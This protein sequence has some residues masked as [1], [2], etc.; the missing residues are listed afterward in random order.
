MARDRRSLLLLLAASAICPFGVA[1]RP[2][3]AQTDVVGIDVV[4]HT[5]SAELRWRRPPDPR[6]G[7]LVRCS[8]AGPRRAV[9]GEARP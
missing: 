8:S 2:A 9:R 7:M 4:P 6:P 1:S 3:R 5:F